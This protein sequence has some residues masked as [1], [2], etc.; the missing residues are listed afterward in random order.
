MRVKI[1]FF[2]E[3]FKFKALMLTF[4]I[5]MNV[6]AYTISP[7]YKIIV[8]VVNFVLLYICEFKFRFEKYHLALLMFIAWIGLSIIWAPYSVNINVIPTLLYCLVSVVVLHRFL[9]RES[10]YIALMKCIII[11]A[12]LLAF[13]MVMH[14]GLMTMLTSR[15]DN[16]VVNTNRAGTIFAI[17]LYFCMYLFY[18]EKNKI[19]LVIG[20]PLLFLVFVSGSK[21]A[22]LIAAISIF[23][24]TSLKSGVNSSKMFRNAV[25]GTV[26]VIIGYILIIKIPVFYRIIGA[27]FQEFVD[28]ML[29]RR[30]VLVGEHSIYMRITLSQFGLKGF[31]ESPLWGHGMDSFSQSPGNPWPGRYSHMNYIEIMYNFGVI[32]LALY[33]WPFIKLVRKFRVIRRNIDSLDR[34][35]ITGFIV[36]YSLYGLLGV[37]FNELFD[38]V[39][40]E[41]MCSFVLMK[42]N[43]LYGETDILLHNCGENSCIRDSQGAL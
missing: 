11:S 27:R 13:A 6:F 14:F 24:M 2:S 21:S 29:G 32:G 43:E 1:G 35:F 4:V 17:S 8:V 31:F 12:Y 28:V 38:W 41:M 26:L 22:L 39:V 40:L 34:A 16:S 36:Y 9:D 15:V 3:D 10:R 42:Y 19:Y 25:I 33:Y 37:F 20:L 30:E 5:G 18:K 7:L 23:V